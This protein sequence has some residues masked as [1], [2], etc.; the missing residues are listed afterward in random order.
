MSRHTCTRCQGSGEVDGYHFTVTC[1]R[2]GGLGVEIPPDEPEQEP[3]PR[4]E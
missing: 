2:C 4:D 3:A 1:P